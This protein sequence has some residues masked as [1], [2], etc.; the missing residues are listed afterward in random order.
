MSPLQKV[1][2]GSLWSV[3]EVWRRSKLEAQVSLIIISIFIIFALFHSYSIFIFI[4]SPSWSPFGLELISKCTKHQIILFSLYIIIIDG[5]NPIGTNV[6]RIAHLRSICQIGNPEVSIPIYTNV[7]NRLSS[8]LDHW[9]THLYWDLKSSLGEKKDVT[10]IGLTN[11]PKIEQYLSTGGRI[12][13]F[14]HPCLFI[15]V[16]GTLR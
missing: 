11:S 2:Q 16:G 7:K 12:Q 3:Q 13:G 8:L 5:G 6:L 15:N 10:M 14:Q 4:L 9:W 1:K